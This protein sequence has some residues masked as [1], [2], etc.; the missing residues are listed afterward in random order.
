LRRKQKLY[1]KYSFV[2]FSFAFC[3]LEEGV[4][5]FRHESGSATSRRSEKTHTLFMQGRRGE[6]KK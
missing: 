1:V 5:L 4:G 6:K 3:F 2:D